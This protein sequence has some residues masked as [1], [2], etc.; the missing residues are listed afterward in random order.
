MLLSYG[1]MELSQ[2]LLDSNLPD[3]AYAAREIDRY[4]PKRLTKQYPKLV[5]AHRLKREIIAAQ[6]GNDLVGMMG[7]SFHLR[8]A[9]LS[10]CAIDE[11]TR[12]Y[13]AARDLLDAPTFISLIQS[14]DNRIDARLQL[15][16]LAQN[17]AMMRQCIIRLLRNQPAPLNIA[18]LV[19]VCRPQCAK[20]KAALPRTLGARARHQH[21]SR[22][23]ELRAANVPPADAAQLAALAWLGNAIDIIEIARRERR[24]LRLCASVYFEVGELLGLDW[25]DAAIDALPTGN[26]WHDR[27]T[28]GL[29]NELR[30]S[31]SAIARKVL[32]MD[33]GD[34][35]AALLKKW[36]NANR[37]MIGMIE[38]MAREL[39][40]E[41]ADFAML[42]VLISELAWLH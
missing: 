9:D 31:H 15:T 10:G 7:A 38:E 29:G 16:L 41:Q 1:K 32:A 25:L 36:R 27:A 28:F 17:A 42:S 34:S 33:S 23:D 11:L 12:A 22:I 20:L 40:N 6:L 2:V 30:A 24:A 21:Q 39:Q 37:R 3:D 19:D 18:K 8:L 14:L 13:V 4:F 35:G 26:H 5:R